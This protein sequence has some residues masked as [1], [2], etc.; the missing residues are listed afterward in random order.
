[1]RKSKSQWLGNKANNE[2][3]DGL[4]FIFKVKK[5]NDDI[6]IEKQIMH[7]H[8]LFWDSLAKRDPATRFS[9]CD[10]DITFIGTGLEE[11]AE[12]KAAYMEINNKGIEQSPNPFTIE[13]LWKRLS[14]VGNIAWVES[15]VVWKQEIGETIF[16]DRIRS[17][18]I[19]KYEKNKW[20]IVHVHGS[21]PDYRFQGGNYMTNADTII[22]NNELERQVFERTD[23]LNKTLKNLQA[24]QKQLVQSEKMAS[25]GEL[26]AGIAHEI[27]NPLNFVNNFSEV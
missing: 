4:K 24:T 18:T 16:R 14:H 7:T 22:R 19:L 11:Q 20:L 17:T 26:T 5:M 15:E 2:E 25:L 6:E 3:E 27:Q 13:F 21:S 8:D 9:I 10:D 12:N 1:M 23:E